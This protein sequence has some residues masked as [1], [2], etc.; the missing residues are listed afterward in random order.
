MFRIGYILGKLCSLNI[1]KFVNLMYTIMKN[2]R[3]SIHSLNNVYVQ[4]TIFDIFFEKKFTLIVSIFRP[5]KQL[6]KPRELAK[7]LLSPI[8]Q[9]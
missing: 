5:L 8:K 7:L 9:I 3:N 1:R 6:I 2:I 4:C